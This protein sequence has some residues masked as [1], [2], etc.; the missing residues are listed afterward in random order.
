ML[1]PH[2]KFGG[3]VTPHG[4]ERGNKWVF[5]FACLFFGLLRLRSVHLWAMRAHCEG[6]IV[7]IYRSIFM[8]FSAFL[9]EAT[10][11]DI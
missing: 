10:V 2:A 6:Y 11:V 5:L 8:Q 9:E 1:Y 3:D 4:G 7:A